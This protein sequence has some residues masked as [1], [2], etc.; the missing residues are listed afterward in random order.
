ME[1]ER[2]SELYW[3]AV[4]YLNDIIESEAKTKEE[5]LEDLENDLL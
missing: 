1:E 3:K 2:V 5:I 4:G